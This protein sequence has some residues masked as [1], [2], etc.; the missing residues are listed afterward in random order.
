MVKFFEFGGYCFA[1]GVVLRTVLSDITL[2]SLNKKL[3]NIY[4]LI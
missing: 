2:V 1:V 4:D 3:L